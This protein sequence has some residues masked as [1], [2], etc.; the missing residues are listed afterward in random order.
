VSADDIRRT[1]ES[2]TVRKPE[3]LMRDYYV[4]ATRRP[5]KAFTTL[6][7]HWMLWTARIQAPDLAAARTKAI[8][9]ITELGDEYGELQILWDEAPAYIA[10]PVLA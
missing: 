1:A 5:R 10:R 6:S 4:A 2:L 9:L 3:P 7:P 8:E